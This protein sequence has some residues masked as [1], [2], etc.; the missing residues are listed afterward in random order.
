MTRMRVLLAAL[1][2]SA[3]CF[4]QAPTEMAQYYA[5]FLRRGPAW[6]AADTPEVRAVSQGHMDNI[7]KL[8]E[9]GKMVVAGPFL[10]QTGER[11]LAG[12]F[13]LRADV[14]PQVH[15]DDWGARLLHRDDAHAVGQALFSIGSI[16]SVGRKRSEKQNQRNEPARHDFALRAIALIES[17]SA[18]PAQC[19]DV[20]HPSLKISPNR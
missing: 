1:V 19:E 6:T 5:V 11:A 2:I 9:A 4:A 13:I 18:A 3:S 8:T 16:G 17:K 10:D 7:R 12:L 15:R 14:I 20:S